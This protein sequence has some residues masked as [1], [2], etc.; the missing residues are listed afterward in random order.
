[1]TEDPRNRLAIQ[2]VGA[3]IAVILW[4][5]MTFGWGLI[6]WQ[7]FRTIVVILQVL[8]LVVN[9]G[10]WLISI[11]YLLSDRAGYS[12]Y[13]RLGDDRSPEEF[14]HLSLVLRLVRWV[15]LLTAIQFLAIAVG[16]VTLLIIRPLL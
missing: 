5:T 16:L 4:E 6:D 2:L 7:P 15:D 9:I 3:S 10:S 12:P 14:M 8:P 1:M 11:V 13:V